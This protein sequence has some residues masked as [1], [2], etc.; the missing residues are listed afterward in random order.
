MGAVL[1]VLP[2]VLAAVVGAAD[3]SGASN[4]GGAA[5]WRAVASNGLSRLRTL[6]FAGAEPPLSSALAGAPADPRERGKLLLLLAQARSGAGKGREAVAALDRIDAASMPED[7]A[8][9]LA[10][11]RAHALR[12]AADPSARA[13]LAD[14]VARNPGSRR[15]TDA[16]LALARLALEPAALG[17]AGRGEAG[18][19]AEAEREARAVLAGRPGRSDRAEAT[20]LL[21]RAT[22]DAALRRRVFVEWP[23]T[24][25]AA[26]AGVTEADLTPAEQHDRADAFFE[27]LDY[28]EAQ[29]IRTAR[30]EAGDRGPQLAYKL[31]LSHLVHVRDDAR[32]AMRYLEHARKGGAVSSAD[33]AFLRARAHAKLEEYGA[34]A[35]EYRQALD[36]GI[37]GDRRIRA[38]YYLGWLPYDHGH[39]EKALPHVDRFLREV[40]KHDLRSYVIWAKGWSLYRLRRWKDAIR[41]FEKDMIPLGNCLVAGKAMYWAGMASRHAGD[42]RAASRW[43]RKVVDRYPLTWYAVLGAKRLAEW[44]GAALPAWITGPAVGLP[45]PGPLWPFDRLPDDVAAAL[46]RVKDLAEVGEIERAREAYEGISKDVERRLSGRDKAAF[47]LTIYDAIEGYNELFR[48]AQGEFGRMMGDVPGAESA[49]YWMAFY[50]R[51]HR[52]LA[53]V[54]APRFGLPEHWI[55]AIMRQESRY[56]PG[57]VSHTAALGIMQMIPKTAKV[58]ARALSVPFQV[59]TFFAPGRN[60]LFCTWYLG[61]LLRDFKGQIVFASAAYNTGAPSIKRFLHAR[62]GA[63]LDEMVELIPY[64]E[65]RNYCRK[66]AEHL[67]R[68]AWLHVPPAERADLYRKVFPDKVDYDLGTAVDF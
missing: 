26:E 62:R 47:L 14:F 10:F 6:D 27:A 50:P 12:I 55:Y 51:A 59:E 39:Y 15:I 1:P 7:L 48:R 25:A 13:A 45:D 49:L 29:R 35:R 58:V 61:E 5:D 22:G 60:L 41:V 46:R 19:A 53:S 63:P 23:D 67:I 37:R 40:K 57:Q 28:D 34:A 66:V 65:G 30:W 21:A 32:K 42:R 44:D 4:G 2:W 68:Y 8:D 38:L 33:A 20:L 16:R 54:L 43:M 9:V 31:A 56:S 36:S 11:E 24:P 52:S 3:G 18:A 17:A 64:N